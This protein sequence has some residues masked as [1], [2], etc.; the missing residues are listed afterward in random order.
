MSLPDIVGLIGAVFYLTAYA[1]LQ[2]RILTVEDSRTTLL[3]VLGGI[4]L[5][6]S[7]SCNFNL[8]SLVTQV[9]WL[10]FTVIGYVRFRVGRA[11]R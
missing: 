1:L 9:A 2:L 4:C 7:L 3:N 10:I 6:Y 8:G 11:S 5:I